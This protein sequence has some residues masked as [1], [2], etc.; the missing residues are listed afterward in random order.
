MGL[1]LPE[2]EDSDEENDAKKK[3]RNTKDEAESSDAKVKGAV[4]RTRSLLDERNATTFGQ[5]VAELIR[6]R[7]HVL[8][9]EK[10]NQRT[11]KKGNP[12]RYF[13]PVRNR[14]GVFNLHA[15]RT[16]IREEFQALWSSQESFDGP[17]AKILT[18]DL[19][20]EL[21]DPSGDDIWRHKGLLF[22][23]RRT[24]WDTGTLGRCDLE[25]TDRC[26]PIADRHAS[27]FRV[28]ETVNN[29]RI[30]RLGEPDQPLTVE[31][32]LKVI[33]LLQGPLFMKRKGELVPKKSASVTDIRE[34]L[35]LGRRRKKDPVALNLEKDEER[36]INTDWFHREVVIAAIGEAT[37]QEWND[38]TKEKLNRALLRFDP[39]VDDDAERVSNFARELALGSDA[40]DRLVAVW[41]TRPKLER[42]LKLSRRAV[43]NLLSFME[44]AFTD[45]KRGDG[46]IPVY[47]VAECDFDATRHRWL[48][49]IEAREAFAR[50][51]EATFKPTGDK[52]ADKEM[53][54]R[55]RRYQLGGNP[56]SSADRYFMRKH[57]D[58]LPPAP[59]MA[60]PVVRK[61]IH[62]VRRHVIAYVREFRGKPDRIV[63]EFARETTKSAK[64]SDR[65]LFRNRNRNRIRR[66][67]VDEV[68]RPV[69]GSRE[70]NQLSN[71]QMRAA[72]DRIILCIQQ[73]GVCAYSA[74]KFDGNT[75]G[76]C[77]YS[78]RPISLR[79]AALG[80]GLEVDHIIPYSRCGD[81]SLS[82]RVLCYREANR[83]KTNKTPR[84]WWG[85]QFEERIAPVRFMDGYEPDRRDYFTK[86]DY[87]AKW[88]NFARTEVPK[89]WHG[90]KLTDT[91]YAAREVQTYLQQALWPD[92]PAFHQGDTNRRVFVTKG[93]YTAILR[94]DLRLY[95]S[96]LNRDASPEEVRHAAAKNRGD[97]R[98]H[99]IDG[100]AIAL[101]PDG[102]QD[103]AAYAKRVDEERE[104][105]ASQGRQPRK[106]KRNPLPPPWGN[107]ES[108]RREV[109][110]QL[111][112]DVEPPHDRDS[113]RPQLQRIV[114]SHR[115]DGRK[116][117]GKLHEDT[118]FGPIPDGDSL[119]T[120]HKAVADLEANHLRMPRGETE[121]QAIA[122]IAKHLLQR[123]KEATKAK[124]RKRAKEIVCSP[125]FKPKLVD[126][127]PEKSGLVRDPELRRILREE[128]TNRIAEYNEQVVQN[129]PQEKWDK[130]SIKND[131]DSFDKRDVNKILK[132]GPLRM[133][134]GVPI[135]RVILLRTMKDP[136][137]VPRR[138]FDH[139]QQRWVRDQGR[140]ESAPEANQRTRADRAYVGGN[141]HHIEIREDERGRWSGVIVPTF[142]AAR[143]VRIE[144]RDAVDRS[145]DDAKGGR[146]MMSLAEGETVY[147]LHKDTREPG[148]FVVFKLDKPQKI[149]FKPHWDARRAKGEK[150]DHGKLIVGSH[151][152]E[153]PVSAAQLKALAPPGE[154]TPIKVAIDPLGRPRRIE[155]L[156]PGQD[157]PEIDPRVMAIA[158]DAIA[159][160]RNREPIAGGKK[161]RRQPGSWSWMHAR[162]SKE[163][164]KH[165]APQLS[166]VMRLLDKQ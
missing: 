150:D 144:K 110:C 136:V 42:R 17:L 107:V 97:H 35:G 66:Q 152:E 100:V 127:P 5:L 90:S 46:P 81:N 50:H 34:A 151:R 11:S 153:I 96:L 111:F 13:D 165:L 128:I 104:K 112:E 143:R 141:N 108:F 137:V 63:I 99:A 122:R 38:E 154:A 68:V 53:E 117:V 145:D 31:Q 59:T 69:F 4:D 147:M 76:S 158:R 95:R 32:R 86:R 33:S 83:D 162:L 85:D 106:L 41:Q 7:E 20:L 109:L 62:E 48:T 43:L 6:E 105:A 159:A 102:M 28:I 23:Q 89:E 91:A 121:K 131:V 40:V 64:A 74:G 98:E 54:H 25:P 10:G 132:A 101:A 139:E 21:D 134:S 1:K 75:E 44:R 84:E 24:Y 118:L 56:L 155:P 2:P 157:A 15:D 14:G 129:E 26:V 142:E 123:R 39:Q 78:G 58:V 126:P 88:R 166:Q 160:R 72:V 156:S 135:K 51:H 125:G 8:R 82:N 161:K 12:S 70:F 29:I 77:A 93:A 27:Y 22:G 114:V 55:I 18:D 140:A 80:H 94:K 92:E 148:Y 164:I 124:A 45:L 73:R 79:Q 130:L 149:Q 71:N 120:G 36:E 67:I 116:L 16:M 30:Q 52:A 103:L 19:L 61:A 87:A 133:P 49:Q 119:Y 65:I 113:S 163:K 37:W 115:P 146:F 57:P 9:D 60:N 138:R 3:R 47:W